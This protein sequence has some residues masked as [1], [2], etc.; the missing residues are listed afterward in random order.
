VSIGD[1]AVVAAQS[2]VAGDLRG[3][4]RYF[5]S[6]AREHGKQ[7]RLMAYANRLPELFER[8]KELERRLDVSPE[9]QDA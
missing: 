7:L 5:G 8:V 9:E 1:G 4:Q 6:P 3:G 2:G